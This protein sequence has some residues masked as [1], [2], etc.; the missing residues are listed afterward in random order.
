[1]IKD[2]KFILP[3]PVAEHGFSALIQISEFDQSSSENNNSK[4][5]LFDAGVSENGVLHSAGVFGIDI[6]RIDGIISSHGHFDHFAGLMNII[7][8]ISPL[9]SPKL[10]GTNYVNIFAHPDA[11]LRRWE[12]VLMER[13]QSAQY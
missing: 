8:R 5:F 7:K 10:S 6:D 11:F 2:E 12:V 13:Q 1:M 4:K 3:P 9:S